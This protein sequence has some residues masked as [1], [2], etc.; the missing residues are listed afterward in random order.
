MNKGKKFGRWTEIEKE[1]FYQAIDQ[2]DVTWVDISIMVGT[3]TPTQCRSHYQKIILK[4]RMN[5][6]KKGLK[7]E[8]D[9]QGKILNKIKNEEKAT[10][11]GLG[12]EKCVKVKENEDKSTW[13]SE[14]C[15]TS[16]E[17]RGEFRVGVLSEVKKEDDEGEVT[18]YEDQNDFEYFWF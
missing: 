7:A 11:F 15:F 1:A 10:G 4:D 2:K 6:M 12:E 9:D 8:S 18:G 3:R 5:R 14:D 16:P 17:D 13:T